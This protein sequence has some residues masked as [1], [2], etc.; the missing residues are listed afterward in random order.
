[1]A[2]K[3]PQ[4]TWCSFMSTTV[5]PLLSYSEDMRSIC[6]L[7]DE[8]E[9][10]DDGDD[11][12]DVTMRHGSIHLVLSADLMIIF[13]LSDGNIDDYLVIIL[14]SDLMVIAMISTQLSPAHH[15][16][17]CRWWGGREPRWPTRTAAQTPPRSSSSP[18]ISSFEMVN[19]E[20]EKKWGAQF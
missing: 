17:W 8:V 14:S 6:D 18:T 9:D 13:W 10:E 16:R 20:R 5:V 4:I 19:V 3:S 12:M 15:G 1:M 7:V 11:A 2:R